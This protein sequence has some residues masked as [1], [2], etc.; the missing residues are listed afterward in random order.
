MTGEITLTG[1][2]LPI[3]GLKEKTLAAVRFKKEKVIIPHE[4][5][6]D[7]ADMPKNILKKIDFITAGRAMDVFKLVFDEKI[8]NKEKSEPIKNLQPDQKSEN[9]KI[10]INQGYDSIAPQ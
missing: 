9:G 3:G 7:I 2:I 10:I 5:L 8:F 4:N 6:K 1:K